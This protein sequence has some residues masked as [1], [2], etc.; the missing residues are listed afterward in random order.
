LNE[1]GNVIEMHEHAGGFKHSC[2]QTFA[3]FRC[4]H[5]RDFAYATLTI[6]S[7]LF[8]F[9]LA[10]WNDV[11]FSRKTQDK[12]VRGLNFSCCKKP[13]LRARFDSGSVKRR[14][15]PGSPQWP[16]L[17]GMAAASSLPTVT[18]LS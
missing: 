1:A 9:T 5:S 14:C 3:R 6:V 7:S 12:F 4:V 11:S 18:F 13:Q 16:K 10:V 15:C 8:G 17:L 2:A